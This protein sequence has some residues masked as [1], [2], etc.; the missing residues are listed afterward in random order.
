MN[1][2]KHLFDFL[3]SFRKLHLVKEIPYSQQAW[4]LK[5]AVII[6]KVRILLL[7]LG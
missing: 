7:P 3:S 2:W 1:P 5:L 6:P 4:V